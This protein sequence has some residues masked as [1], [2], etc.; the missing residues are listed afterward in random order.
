MKNVKGCIVAF[1][2][3]MAFML[4]VKI[5][6]GLMVLGQVSQMAGMTG[7][8]MASGMMLLGIC[9]EVLGVLVIWLPAEV[10][11]SVHD[12]VSSPLPPPAS[13]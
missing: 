3:I 10:L 2:I 4:L 9:S 7:A 6:G 5:V 8:G 12:K 13:R 11:F 1:R